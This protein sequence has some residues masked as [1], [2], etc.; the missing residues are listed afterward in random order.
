MVLFAARFLRCALLTGAT[1]PALLVY[2]WV[3]T[4]KP[5]RTWNALPASNV[6][7]LLYQEQEKMLVGRGQLEADLMADTYTPLQANIVK[8]AGSGGGFGGGSSKGK[9]QKQLLKAQG[10]AHADVLRREG[11]VRIDNVLPDKIADEM[12]KFAYDLRRLSEE[13]VTNKEILPIQR[14]ADVLLKTNRCDLTIPLGSTLVADALCNLL[15]HSPVGKTLEALLSPDA[16]LYEL[17]C[18][19]SDPGS[20]RQVVHP[21]TPCT[22]SNDEPALY[23]CFVALQDVQID[24]GPTT[25]IPGTHRVDAHELF[26]D[27]SIPAGGIESS[28]DTLLRT[29]P[30]VLG[31]LPKGSCGLFDSRL[32]HCGGANE[33]EMSR[34]LFYVS[35]KN[36]KLVNP[37]NPGSIRR[38]YISQFTLSQLD[39]ELTLYSK[40]KDSSRIIHPLS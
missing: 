7:D 35:F 29:R 24:M 36:P 37:G 4:S 34:A 23:T 2:S 9:S 38:E 3:P 5:V 17:S 26:K 15:Q 32:L 40:G 22:T 13:Q 25:W 10:K 14:F 8:G 33:S 6:P 16:V 30:S 31:L 21:D 28:K 11:V 39:K 20:Q 1:V 27:E 19:M 12:R 18:L